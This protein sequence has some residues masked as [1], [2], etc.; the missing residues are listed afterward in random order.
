MTTDAVAPL[1]EPL[2]AELPGDVDDDFEPVDIDAVIALSLV[3]GDARDRIA[4]KLHIDRAEVD[5][6]IADATDV[7]EGE[8]LIE[9]EWIVHERLRDLTSQASDTDL[10]SYETPRLSL[11]LELA[12]AELGLIESARRRQGGA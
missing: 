10:A 2:A 3:R 5:A 12:K 1:A 9:R 4:E 7:S 6:R 11:L 8:S